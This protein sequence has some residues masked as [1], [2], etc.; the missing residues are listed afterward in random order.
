MLPQKVINKY[1][2]TIII[3]LNYIDGKL[4]SCLVGQDVGSILGLQRSSVSMSLPD[5]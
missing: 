5:P 1:F 4:Y 3:V 2:D